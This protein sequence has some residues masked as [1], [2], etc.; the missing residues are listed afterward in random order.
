[1]RVID[2]LTIAAILAGPIIAIQISTYLAKR[3]EHGARKHYVFKTLMATRASRLS[4]EHVQALN[5]I[6]IEFYEKRK[7]KNS[8]NKAVLDA[9]KEYLDLLGNNQLKEKSPDVWYAKADDLFIELMHQMAVALGY[10]FD[11]TAIKNT[12]Y[13][14]VAHGTIEDEQNIIRRGFAAV[15]KGETALPMEIVRPEPTPEEKEQQK[16]QQE[17]QAKMDQLQ[18]DYLSG[19]ISQK[20]IVIR[21]EEGILSGGGTPKLLEDHTVE[22]PKA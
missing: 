12:S 9:W 8:R 4:F 7:R 6:D 3:K 20:V 10:D 19:K 15:F 1:M 16:Q 18:E 14:P 22:P 11:K 21:D 5:M 13:I 2:W 17:R